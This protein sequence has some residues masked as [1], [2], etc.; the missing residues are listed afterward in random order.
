MIMDIS[1]VSRGDGGLNGAIQFA[2]NN[3]RNRELSLGTLK[4]A[5]GGLV[6]PE[7][8]IGQMVESK[9][10]FFM[11]CFRHPV[12]GKYRMIF[13]NPNP[14]WFLA[15]NGFYFLEAEHLN[16]GTWHYGEVWEQEC[17][18]TMA[19]FRVLTGS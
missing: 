18:D 14:V 15:N 19:V 7:L 16:E 2:L 3:S 4:L 9:N 11:K 13:G 17:P 8:R 10:G 1:N 6:I 5:L 12:D